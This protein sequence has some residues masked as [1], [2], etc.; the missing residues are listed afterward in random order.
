MDRDA[1]VDMADTAGR[2]PLWIAAQN[3]HTGVVA[4]L[5]DQA[6]VLGGEPHKTNK[7]GWSPLFVACELFDCMARGARPRHRSELGMPRGNISFAM[8]Q[9][10]QP[11]TTPK[12]ETV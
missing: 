9:S 8:K 11:L 4:L 10:H 12:T 2:S 7:D 3:G 6:G 5:L 1:E